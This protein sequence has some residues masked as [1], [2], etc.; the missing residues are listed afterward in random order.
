MAISPDDIAARRALLAAKLELAGK[1]DPFLLL[2][3]MQTASK[4]E[5]KNAYFAVAKEVHPDAYSSPEWE[6]LRDEAEK[7]FRRLNEAY[8]ILSDDGKRA[9]WLARR[10]PGKPASKEELI[11]GTA[12][13][14]AEM[15]F[16]EG[17]VQ[18]KR[19]DINGA[20]ASFTRAVELNPREGEHHALLAWTRV[21]AGLV[22][23]TAIRIELQKA[24]TL[25]PKCARAHYYLG[26]LLHEEGKIDDAIAAV[27]RAVKLD[28]RLHEAESLLR[29][30]RTRR[31][32]KGWRGL[33]GRAG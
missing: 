30:L 16:L 28:K 4:A 33:F 17:E 5:I 25:S 22:K 9:T 14:E 6:V 26:A 15:A 27:D 8:A 31:E 2:G 10:A 32:K 23:L 7:V 21:A 12:M 3:L 11:S 18:L 20:L 13:V 1:D 24:L 29:L 19:R